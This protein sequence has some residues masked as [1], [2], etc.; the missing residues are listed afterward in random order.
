MRHTVEVGDVFISLD[1]RRP[2]YRL[3]VEDMH[4][5]GVEVKNESTGRV[6]VI[7][8]NRLSMPWKYYKAGNTNA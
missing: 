1:R 6:T 2:A 5:D 4:E 8:Q 7:S 3:V